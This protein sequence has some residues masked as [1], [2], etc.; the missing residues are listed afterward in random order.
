MEVP[1]AFLQRLANYLSF[2]PYRDV[3]GLLAELNQLVQASQ[4]GNKLVDV[5]HDAVELST[6][7]KVAGNGE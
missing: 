2:Q 5:A 7:K 1:D 4:K 6:V 3:A